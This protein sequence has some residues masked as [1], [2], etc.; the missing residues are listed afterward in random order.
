MPRLT[1]V[2]ETKHYSFA[3][4]HVAMRKN[5][6]LTYLHSDHLGSTV[7]ETNPSAALRASASG[8]MT[9]DETYFAY[10]KQC[11]SGKVTTDH[12]FTGQKEDGSGLMC[13]NARYLRPADRACS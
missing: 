1:T 10:G 5:G 2:T 12:C 11:D 8:A 7:L 9:T 4:Q 3:G 6:V 13:Y